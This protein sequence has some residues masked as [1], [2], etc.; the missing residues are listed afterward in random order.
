MRYTMSRRK[1]ADKTE[2]GVQFP[3]IRYD[4]N[5][6]P[7]QILLESPPSD[8]SPPSDSIFQKS[9]EPQD[10]SSVILKE[11]PHEDLASPTHRQYSFHRQSSQSRLESR[12]ALPVGQSHL[13][14]FDIDEWQEYEVDSQDSS[15]SDG[16]DRE[17]YFLDLTSASPNILLWLEVPS[18]P[19]L[20]PTLPQWPPSPSS[21]SYEYYKMMMASPPSLPISG[22]R[23]QRSPPNW[24]R[25]PLICIPPLSAGPRQPMF[26]LQ[27]PQ[28]SVENAQQPTQSSGGCV[29]Q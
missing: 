14:Q 25:P 26:A 19:R 10:S 22:V 24:P 7:S 5:S 11:I 17:E 1:N 23:D 16:S 8:T 4:S 29:L 21:D 9:F 6:P 3:S 27:P 13:Y 2:F 15:T 18:P 28:D 12:F 20:Y